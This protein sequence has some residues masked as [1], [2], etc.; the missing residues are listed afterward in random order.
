MPTP[1]PTPAPKT[2]DVKISNQSLLDP[3]SE[4]GVSEDIEVTLRKTLHNNGPSGPREVSIS[5][6]ATAPADCT[7]TPDLSNHTQAN[8][9]VSTDVVVDEVWAIH[10]SEEGEKT[11]QFDNSIALTS[12][13]F[14]DPDPTNNTASTWWTVECR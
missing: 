11:F 7:A 9:P 6:S 13:A 2:A 4:I 14:T 3:P 1:T 5:V 10:C 8:L 12:P